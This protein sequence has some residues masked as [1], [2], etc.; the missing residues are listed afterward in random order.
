MC[1][2]GPD[3]GCDHDGILVIVA[4]SD[5]GGSEKGYPTKTSGEPVKTTLIDFPTQDI[6]LRAILYTECSSG[7]L[8]QDSCQHVWVETFG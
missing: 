6:C 5:K 4:G 1:G 2:C 3:Q 7:M 8:A